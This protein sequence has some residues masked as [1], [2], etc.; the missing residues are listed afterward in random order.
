MEIRNLQ[1]LKADGYIKP[2][3][4]IDGFISLLF[5]A[6]SLFFPREIFSSLVD[7]SEVN[8]KSLIFSALMSI[9]ILY[10][11]LGVVCIYISKSEIF[12]KV[13]FS[14]I[15]LFYHVIFIFKNASEMHSDWLIGNPWPDIGIH[16]TFSTLY[17]MF[18][19][20]KVRA[21]ESLKN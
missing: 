14:V 1:W 2:V 12:S 11:F 5:G 18:I 21:G 9:S 3:I 8:E 17:F 10:A 4:F 6:A 13:G 20:N 7:I 16:L 19:V 15:M